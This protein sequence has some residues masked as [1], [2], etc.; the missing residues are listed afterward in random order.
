M[1]QNLTVEKREVVTGVQHIC[2]RCGAESTKIDGKYAEFLPQG[3]SHL[4]Y[5]TPVVDNG[6]ITGPL[7]D[8]KE[9]DYCH[10]CTREILRLDTGK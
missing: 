4:R 3:W 6:G 1:T 2:D 7:D 9:Y 5:V 8:D 10:E